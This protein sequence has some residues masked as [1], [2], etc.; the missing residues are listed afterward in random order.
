MAHAKISCTA[1]WD[2]ET[3]VTVSEDIPDEPNRKIDA[4]VK[5]SFNGVWQPWEEVENFTI[6]DIPSDGSYVEILGHRITGDFKTFEEF[7]EY[8]KDLEE[9]KQKYEKLLAEKHEAKN[10]PA[11]CD[12]TCGPN[13]EAMYKDCFEKLDRTERQLHSIQFDMHNLS[14]EHAHYTGAV[15]AMETI[16]GRKFEPQR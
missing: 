12:K 16:F 7:L 4:P 5:A 14:I 15:A 10:I 2:R 6:I 13:W 8:L 11:G 3:L 1:C 9:T